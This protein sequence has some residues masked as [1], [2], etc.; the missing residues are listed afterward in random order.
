MWAADKGQSACV[1]LLLDAGAN[2]DLKDNVRR[3][4]SSL[5]I[6]I[7]APYFFIERS[8]LDFNLRVEQTLLSCLEHLYIVL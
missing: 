7:W 3:G 2:K 8:V 5:S 4:V 1:R 6:S